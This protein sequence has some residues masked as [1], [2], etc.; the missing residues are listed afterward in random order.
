MANIG[1]ISSTRLNKNK[2]AVQ[3]NQ[4]AILDILLTAG[5]NKEIK[6]INGFT[7]VHMAAIMNAIDMIPIFKKHNVSLTTLDHN[8]RT[9]NL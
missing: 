7:I 3:R 1:Y 9:P 2:Y 5:A 4:P 8:Q 6:S